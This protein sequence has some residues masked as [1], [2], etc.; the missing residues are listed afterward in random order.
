MSVIATA[1]KHMLAAGMD[2]DPI[3]AA[4]AEMEREVVAKEEPVLSPRQA[5]NT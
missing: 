3:V 2:H 1:L 4:V 5:G